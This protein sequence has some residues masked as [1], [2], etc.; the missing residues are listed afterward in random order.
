MMRPLGDVI[1]VMPPI[2]IDMELLKKLLRII[3]N[4]IEND[5]PQIVKE[6]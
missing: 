3:K 1:V 6:A 5:L 4:S 2:A